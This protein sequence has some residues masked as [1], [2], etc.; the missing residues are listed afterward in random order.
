MIT[1]EQ[2]QRIKELD[3]QIEILIQEKEKINPYS[4]LKSLSNKEFGEGFSENLIAR[5]CP[6]LIHV[7][8]KGYD[9]LS[10]KIGKIEVK[11]SRLPCKHITLNQL[12]PK[13]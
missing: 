4:N 13:D 9:F 8:G 5:Q 1:K 2:Q 11:S 7:S 10:D 6:Q 12:H 3:E